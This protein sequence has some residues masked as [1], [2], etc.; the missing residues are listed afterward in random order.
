M[1]AL[2]S[3][4]IRENAPAEAGTPT[5]KLRVCHL[6]L[7]LATGGLERLLVDL[8]RF[9]DRERFEFTFLAMN[10][11]GRPA[12]DIR[13]AG[14]P[15]EV[16]G[17]RAQGR[18]SRVV[19]LARRFRRSSF[20]IVH[21]H[22]A[23]P[24]IYGT[25]A[26]RLAGV[27]IVVQT[28]HGPRC[29]AGWLAGLQYRLACRW[30]NRVVGVSDDAARIFRDIEH[31]PAQ[32]VVRIWNGIDVERFRYSGPAPAPT[33]ISVAR[34]S[35]EKDFATL[36]R[37]AALVAGDLPEFRLQIVGDGPDRGR[38]EKLARELGVESQVQF[39]GER[40]DVPQLLAQAGFFV[41]ATLMEGVSLTLLEAMAVGLP[42]VTTAVGGNPEVVVEWETG[43]LVP[44]AEPVRLAAAIT[45]MC[46]ERAR[47][48]EMGRRARER[49]VQHFDVRR[50]VQ[51]YE[52]L[53]EREVAVVSRQ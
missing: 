3:V 32:K 51:E 50:M 43:F 30:G 46:S 14:C 21:T 15:V 18:L 37:A 9:H 17:T 19:E 44:A 6:S 40:S 24:H 42:S 27:P 28:R 23:F 22:N 11:A 47:W 41:S 26:A 45:R 10:D 8:A 38:L 7:G 52:R 34:L 5:H 49:V 13:A 16:I 53:Y 1:T 20:D 25:V 4:S 12:E 2:P 33:A 48:P 29:G 31:I 35:P 36:L 39:L